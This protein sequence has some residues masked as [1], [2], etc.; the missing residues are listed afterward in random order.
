MSSLESFPERSG[1]GLVTVLYNVQD[2]TLV[3]LH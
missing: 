2:I 1:E 3:D